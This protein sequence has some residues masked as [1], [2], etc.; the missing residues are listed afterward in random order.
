MRRVPAVARVAGEQRLVAQ[1]LAPGAAVGTDAAGIAEPRHADA[2]THRE[3]GYALPD[4]R[5]PPDDLMA[6]HDRQ[7]RV[8]QVAIDHMKIGAA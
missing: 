1:V 2:L 5:D 6:R 7:F 8:F 3:A 4:R